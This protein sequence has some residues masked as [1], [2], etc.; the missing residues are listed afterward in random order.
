MRLKSVVEKHTTLE[1]INNIFEDES[2]YY[3]EVFA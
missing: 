3:D 2:K 1:H